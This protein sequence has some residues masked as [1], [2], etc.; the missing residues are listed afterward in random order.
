M[1]GPT[2]AVTVAVLLWQRTVGASS[3]AE[4]T[5]GLEDL[6]DGALESM[7]SMAVRDV[8]ATE[9]AAI[10]LMASTDSSTQRQ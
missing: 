8:A 2:S 5:R 9:W 3:P 4:H 6:L 10:K 7:G 1:T